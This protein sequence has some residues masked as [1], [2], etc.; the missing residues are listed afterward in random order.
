MLPDL[1]KGDSDEDANKMPFPTEFELAK[2]E[3]EEPFLL[4]GNPRIS[5]HNPN[6]LTDFLSHEFIDPDLDSLAPKLWVMSTQ[7]SAN[8]SPLHRQRVKGREIIITEEP[9]LHLVWIYDRVFIKPLPRYLLSR[10][11]WEDYLLSDT[12]PLGSRRKEICEAALGFL[13]SYCYLVV[14]ESDFDI[15]CNARLFT[16]GVTWTQFC[17]FS[18]R[19]KQISDSQVSTRYSYGELRLT[20]LNFY[21]KI[22]LRKWQYERVHGQYGAYFSRFYG[23]L[24][25]IFGIWSVILSAMQVGLGVESLAPERWEPFWHLCRWFGV[26]TMSGLAL[27]MLL[28]ALLLGGMIVDE[29]V[30]AFKCLFRKKRQRR[31]QNDKTHG[32]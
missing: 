14:H 28:L 13:R 24:L 32:V 12:S 3:P 30:Y 22:F 25:F 11:F 8:I 21:T 15:A 31:G 6:E 5:L 23:P 2:L 10:K 18:A 29:W 16:P 26:L 4:P 1:I 20:R 7:S 27:L 19:L 9:R 17:N